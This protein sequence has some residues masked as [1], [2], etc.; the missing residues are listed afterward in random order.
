MRI[1]TPQKVVVG[2]LIVAGI[3]GLIY[4]KKPEWLPGGAIIIPTIHDY[5]TDTGSLSV[6]VGG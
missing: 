1:S 3:V 5:T 4:W 6:F 2:G